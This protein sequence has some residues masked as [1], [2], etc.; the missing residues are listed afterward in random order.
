MAAR[1]SSAGPRPKRAW[2]RED[3]PEIALGLANRRKVMGPAH[4]E[5]SLSAADDD[6]LRQELEH[7]VTG[8]AWGAVW[9]R[10][11]LDTKSRC[12]ITL[13]V[14]LAQG[15]HDEVKL[16]LAGALRN[17]WTRDELVEAIIHVACYAGWPAAVQGFRAAEEVFARPPDVDSPM[18][19]GVRNGGATPVR[20]KK[21][22]SQRGRSN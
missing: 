17:G 12:L 7:C 15:R 11:G 8:L 13:S 16:H 18:E 14:L 3:E 22:A 5:R 19:S 10:P 6:P 9:G 2:L 21:S 1:K 20:K 4:V